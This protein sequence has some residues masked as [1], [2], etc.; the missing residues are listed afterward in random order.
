MTLINYD[1]L[2]KQDLFYYL[3]KAVYRKRSDPD[4]TGRKN[5]YTVYTGINCI[6][7]SNTVEALSYT[8]KTG[9]KTSFLHVISQDRMDQAQSYVQS[10]S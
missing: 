3:L 9:L 4:S 5:T 7:D 8:R 6:K 1:I 2:L 10:E